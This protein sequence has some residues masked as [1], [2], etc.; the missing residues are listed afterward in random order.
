MGCCWVRTGLKICNPA[1]FNTLE[2]TTYSAHGTICQ[3]EGG[4]LG[5]QLLPAGM[6]HA[7]ARGWQVENHQRHPRLPR[8][9]HA[10]QGTA[11]HSPVS[12]TQGTLLPPMYAFAQR[13]RQPSLPN[14]QSSW[15]ARKHMV[16]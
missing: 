13:A 12:G 10:G 1:Q 16:Q 8:L 14:K 3:R 15:R 11:L 6:S 2:C 5:S 4:Q 7:H 9:Q